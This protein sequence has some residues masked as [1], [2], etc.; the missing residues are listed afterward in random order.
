MFETMLN[1]IKSKSLFVKGDRIVIGLSGGPDSLAMTDALLKLKKIYQL[2]LFAVHVNHMYRGEHSDADETFVKLYCEENDLP[3]YSFKVDVQ[4]KAKEMGISFEEAGRS[5]RYEK[6]NQV[7]KEVSANKIA[8][9]QNKN[10]LIETFFINLFR[11]AGIDGL[12]SIDYMRDDQY[13]R[14]I[15][16]VSRKDIESYC[17]QNRLMPRHDHTNDENN[18]VRNKIRNV[19][20][21][22]LRDT[23]NPSIDETI[24]K[25]IHI[26]KSEKEFWRVHQ[27]R[28]FDKYCKWL[29]G[30]IH[31]DCFQFDKLLES[32]KYQ[33]LRHCI[34]L[35][36]G[37]LT[38]VS[39]DTIVR[40]T[41]LNRTGSICEIDS[42]FS[43]IK[44]YNVLVLF[45]NGKK[46][47]LGTHDLFIK[48]VSRQE[49]VNYK[50]DHTCVA[51]DFDTVVGDFK[52]RTRKNGDRFVPL[53][54]KG[55]KK[56]KDF[57]IDEKVPK[58]DR[59]SIRI[60][61]DDEK[62]IWIENM[63]LDDR[64]KIS[65]VT[66]NIMILSFQELVERD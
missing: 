11:G 40:I 45:E 65:E 23:F 3:C 48:R 4:S 37:N 10:D 57:Y 29:D 20:L 46:K 43:I 62:I 8:I 35:L 49:L 56:I 30:D 36:R 7:M 63:R 9:A 55:H 27:Q 31:I 44:Q 60:V 13:I 38:N 58:K 66:N 18:Y 28:L 52:V 59:D 22:N 1:T 33:L 50:M 64:C 21:P 24:E 19:L 25:T 47:S 54:M 32:E 15:L 14:P 42:K 34:V 12:A 26:M 61:C 16:D 6:F 41:A 39:F 53:G 17:A 2:E 51:I 5:V